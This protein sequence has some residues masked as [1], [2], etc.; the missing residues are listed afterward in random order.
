MRRKVSP[1]PLCYPHIKKGLLHTY[2]EATKQILMSYKIRVRPIVVYILYEYRTF[3]DFE[4]EVFCVYG[5]S[6]VLVLALAYAVEQMPYFR[7]IVSKMPLI[8]ISL[9]RY[10]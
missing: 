7:G 3:L 8:C 2:K 1:S 4:P 10:C 6:R 5:T 9:R